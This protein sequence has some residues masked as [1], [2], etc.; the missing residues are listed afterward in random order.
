MRQRGGTK[1][2]PKN[3]QD[4]CAGNGYETAIGSHCGGRPCYA[5]PALAGFKTGAQTPNGQPTKRGLVEARRTHAQFVDEVNANTVTIVSGGINGTYVRIAADFASVS[6][7]ATNYGSCRIG[8]GSLQNI[9]IFDSCVGSTSAWSNP[10]CWRASRRKRRF[11]MSEARSPMWRGS[12]TRKSIFSRP[13]KLPI[14][15]N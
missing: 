15:G 13:R 3:A 1:S 12:T 2:R 14:S 6:T 8:R 10:T 7:R 11:R 5:W 4:N 9:R